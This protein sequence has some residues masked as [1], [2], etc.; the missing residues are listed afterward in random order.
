M[1]FFHHRQ[2]LWR[3]SAHFGGLS[4]RRYERNVEFELESQK[5]YG[6]PGGHMQWL[7]RTHV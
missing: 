1:I 2:M 6:I 4:D 5:V 7:L 3:Y